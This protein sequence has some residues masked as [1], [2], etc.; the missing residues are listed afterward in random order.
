MKKIQFHKAMRNGK[1]I[2]AEGYSYK[3]A[4]GLDFALHKEGKVWCATELTSGKL[5]TTNDHLTM[6]EVKAEIERRSSTILKLLQ[7]EQSIKQQKIKPVKV[8]TESEYLA[9]KGLPFSVS[10]FQ[11]DK[12]RIP[13]GETRRQ[14]EKRIKETEEAAKKHFEARKAA[15]AEYK[16][17]VLRGEIREPTTIEKALSTARGHEDLTATQAARRVLTKRGIDWK[18]GKKL[19]DGAKMKKQKVKQQRPNPFAGKDVQDVYLTKNKIAVTTVKTK[20]RNKVNETI[21]K[22]KY[23]EANDSNKRSLRKVRKEVRRGRNGSKYE[24]L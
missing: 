8:Q 18:T 9:E 24:K 7:K 21:T 23:Y 11:A 19:K 5:A 3:T 12:T 6:K 20:R 14:R 1:S 15:R 22:T 17:K 10:S 2:E 4:N 16:E 13:H